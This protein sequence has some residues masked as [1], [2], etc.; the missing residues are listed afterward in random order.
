MTRILIL[1]TTTK[2]LGLLDGRTHPSGFWAEEFV[3]PYERF[4]QA[5]HEVDVATI[6]GVP[7]TVDE[8]SLNTMTVRATRPAGSPDRD[9]EDI[10]HYRKV[11]GE[12]HQLQHP[13]NVSELTRERLAGYAGV[14]VSGGHGAMQDMPHDAHLTRALRTVLELDLPL[15]AVCHGQSALLPLR[16][17]HGRWPLE[18]Y[19]MVAF[20][21][22]EELV[23]DIAGQL[24]FVLQAELERLGAK[25]EKA[26]VIWGSH[27]VEDRNLVTGQNPYSSTELA[28][29]FVRKLDRVRQLT[30]AASGGAPET[31]GMP[32]KPP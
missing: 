28:E 23:T 9:A 10:E 17:S 31:E 6:G 13:M 32:W 19:R 8:G 26:D 20:S 2:E 16:D 5:G 29:A 21:H 1:L 4:V 11:I 15:A 12:L 3:V 25:Y 27:V 24:P 30:R 14:F 18:G 22:D 7:P